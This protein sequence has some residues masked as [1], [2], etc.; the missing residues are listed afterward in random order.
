MKGINDWTYMK[1]KVSSGRWSR[2][3]DLLILNLGAKWQW[4]VN[5]TP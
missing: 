2:G 5:N 1:V 3:T 4:V